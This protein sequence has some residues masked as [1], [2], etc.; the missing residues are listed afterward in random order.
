MG[1]LINKKK[2]PMAFL[3]SLIIKL[4]FLMCTASLWNCPLLKDTHF[5]LPS[6][7]LLYYRQLQVTQSSHP[8]PLGYSEQAISPVLIALTTGLY[9]Y[10]KPM[11]SESVPITC[12]VLF[13]TFTYDLCLLQVQFSLL[14]VKYKVFGD[15]GLAVHLTGISS[16]WLGV[17]CFYQN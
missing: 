6:P 2:T 1:S 14:T 10:S 4:G 5:S 16:K 13:Y 17:S 15:S 3:I 8:T 7:W 11:T 12:L 9:C